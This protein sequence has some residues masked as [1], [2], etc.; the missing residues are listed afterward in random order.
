[1]TI[2]VG[3]LIQASLISFHQGRH[4]AEAVSRAPVTS[5]SSLHDLEST[6]CTFC[7]VI[8]VAVDSS[9]FVPSITS[10]F[11]PEYLDSVV[12]GRIDSKLSLALPGARAPPTSS[13]LT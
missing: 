8:H 10:F 9:I 7:S 5:Q 2:A 13:S 6:G 1:M 4:A 11:A 12:S 3:L